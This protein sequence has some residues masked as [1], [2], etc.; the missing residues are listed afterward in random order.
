MTFFRVLSTARFVFVL[1]G[2]CTLWSADGRQVTHRHQRRPHKPAS[3]HQKGAEGYAGK[4]LYGHMSKAGGATILKTLKEVVDPQYLVPHPEIY[5]L[6][7]AQR[8]AFVIGSIRNPCDFY[9]SLW[10]FQSGGTTDHGIMSDMAK[11]FP[12]DYKR[13]VGEGT[14]KHFTSKSDVARFRK[15]VKHIANK[16]GQVG[17]MTARFYKKYVQKGKHRKEDLRDKSDLAS[18]MTTK[19]I[20]K[21]KKGMSAENLKKL[22]ICWVKTESLFADLKA[23]LQEYEQKS[24]VSVSWGNFHQDLHLTHGSTHAPCNHYYDQETSDLVRNL[25]SHIFDQFGYGSCC[26][27]NTA[28]V[29]PSLLNQERQILNRLRHPES[30][31]PYLSDLKAHYPPQEADPRGLRVEI[32]TVD[33]AQMTPELFKRRYLI[34]RT[35]VI[36]RGASKDMLRGSEHLW[37]PEALVK[38][39]YAGIKQPVHRSA[40]RIVSPAA[41]WMTVDEIFKE[42]DRTVLFDKTKF[43]KLA[44]KLKKKKRLKLQQ[45]YFR[46]LHH[47]KLLQHQDRIFPKPPKNVEATFNLHVSNQGGALPHSHGATINAL[48]YGAKRWFLKDPRTFKSRE[49]QLKFEMMKKHSIHDNKDNYTSHQWFK[50][51]VMD[52]MK[53]PYY[54]FIQEPGDAVFI[55]LYFTHATIDLCRETVG[56]VLMGETIFG[57]GAEDEHSETEL[58]DVHRNVF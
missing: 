13:L 11:R 58:I 7:N 25:D 31:T 19:E 24:N 17:L 5:G 52:N 55:P 32:E 37:T 10:A 12:S 44:G 4:L 40:G 8:S 30:C 41:Q 29:K 16:R 47:N 45:Q 57:K 49:R 27:M 20:A 28:K 21:V 26:A 33:V 22:G 39:R 15:W 48:L 56:V 1:L 43:T 6:N 51:K 54:D 9:V 46:K 53:T 50:D 42:P 2:Y 38:S 34:P 35:P 23:C 3:L 18:A 14:Q 36:L